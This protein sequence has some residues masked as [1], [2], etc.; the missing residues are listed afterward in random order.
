MFENLKQIWRTKG[1]VTETMEHF[2][3]IMQISSEMFSHTIDELKNPSKGDL[4]NDDIYKKD[5]RVNELQRLIRRRIISHMAVNP[6]D[7]PNVCLVLM[8]VVKDAE[9]LGDLSKNIY[10]TAHKI[11]RPLDNDVFDSYFGDLFEQLQSFYTASSEAFTQFDEEKARQLMD[12]EH[13][14]KLKY[15][16]VVDRLLTQNELSMNHAVGFTLLCRFCMRMSVHLNNI[17]TA[18]VMPVELLDYFDEE[19]AE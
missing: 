3:E 11:D 13:Q 18:V 17:C 8:S 10:E 2:A 9:R 19:T 7:E 5:Q 12:Q 1:F 4:Q 14:V 15:G 16:E 6:T